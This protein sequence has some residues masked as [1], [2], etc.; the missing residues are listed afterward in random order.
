MLFCAKHAQKRTLYVRLFHFKH[1]LMN[2]VISCKMRLIT[3]VEKDVP[4]VHSVAP[5]HLYAHTVYWTRSKHEGYN[6]Y[7]F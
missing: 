4:S 5:D 3:P 7:H 1:F 6:S 2:N